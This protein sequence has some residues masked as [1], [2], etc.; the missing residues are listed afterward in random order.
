MAQNELYGKNKPAYSHLAKV[1]T[2]GVLANSQGILA[3]NQSRDVFWREIQSSDVL[4]RSNSPGGTSWISLLGLASSVIIL[5]S[6]VF[7]RRR[8]TYGLGRVLGVFF[9]VALAILFVGATSTSMTTSTQSTVPC[10]AMTGV[11]GP[12]VILHPAN[13]TGLTAAIGGYAIAGVVVN[14]TWSWG[15][16]Q[17]TTGYFPQSHVYS[18]AGTYEVNVTVFDCTGGGKSASA[19]EAVTVGISSASS[20]YSSTRVSSNGPLSPEFYVL[21]AI[22]VVIL[23]ALVFALYT[24][25]SS[26]P[27]LQQV[28]SDSNRP[29]AES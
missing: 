24:R 14:V 3:V 20:S 12:Y 28:G 21:V 9:G 13:V 5:Q 10:S 17:T 7:S 6:L 22:G 23:A 1:G 11:G 29:S 15:D 25:K 8:L 18:R 27:I 19:S 16:G 2:L 4:L 26:R